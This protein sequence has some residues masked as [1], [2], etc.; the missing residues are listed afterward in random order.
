MFF[1]WLGPNDLFLFLVWSCPTAVEIGFL[2]FKMARDGPIEGPSPT[3]SL[4]PTKF[5]RE[6]SCQEFDSTIYD[7]AIFKHYDRLF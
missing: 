6:G 7:T 1:C 3:P 2:D 4:G 5:G